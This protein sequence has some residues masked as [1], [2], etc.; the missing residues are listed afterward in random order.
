MSFTVGVDVGG[1]KIAAGVVDRTGRIV[2]KLRKASPTTD[3]F[4]LL[5]A[6]R[7]LVGE[8]RTRHEITAVGVGAPGFVGADRRTVLFT[9][10]LPWRDEPLAELLQRVLELPVLVEN[11]ANAAAWAEFVFGAGRGIPDQLLLTL[12]TGV[13]GGLILDGEVYRGGHGVAAE[14]GHLTVV[15]DGIPCPCGRHGCLEQY[16]SGSALVREARAAAASGRAPTLLEAAGGNVLQVTGAMVT[17]HAHRGTPEAVELF[18]EMGEALAVGIGSLIAVLDP[19]LVLLGG[20]VSEAGDLILAPT[21]AALDRELTGGTHRP[22]PE[23]RLA[24]LGNDAGLIGA[25]DEAR[26]L[27]DQKPR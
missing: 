24:A 2:E 13:G 1:T 4:S 27:V 26:R 20:G 16:A 10:N 6:I 25:A 12:G 18:E 11:D 23:V 5:K 8:L 14:V 21:T 9:P 17:E 3:E 22:G 7:E 15:R 19:S